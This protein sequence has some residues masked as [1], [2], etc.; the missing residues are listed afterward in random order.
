MEAH[1]DAVTA[2]SLERMDATISAWAADPRN[3]AS[4]QGLTADEKKMYA[5]P[6]KAA[7]GCELGNCEKFKVPDA[8]RTDNPSR[9][10]AAARWASA[11]KIVD[12][13][14]DVE[15]RLVAQGYRNRD[16][17][18]GPVETSGCVRSLLRVFRRFLCVR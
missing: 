14:R 1:W 9:P 7:K 8:V 13:K 10:I 11:W 5:A 6:R 15:A 12:C 2:P 16:L 18:A 4:S 17:K 3:E